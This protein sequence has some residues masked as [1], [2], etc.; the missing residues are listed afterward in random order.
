[1]KLVLQRVSRASVRVNGKTV[2]EIGRG[3][4]VLACVE[5]GDADATVRHVGTRLPQLRIFADEAGKMNLSLAEVGGEIL[6]VSQFTLAANLSRGRRPGFENAA[7]PGEARRLFDL[8][9]AALRESGATV[10]T[11]VFGAMMDVE[12]V[13]D[14]PVTFV[15][16]S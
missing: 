8:F 9:V 3:M 6:A 12:L 11:G 5:K 10:R 7:E 2:S 16:E 15:L 14:G 4:L 13:N 1:M